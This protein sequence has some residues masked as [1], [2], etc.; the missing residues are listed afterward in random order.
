MVGYNIDATNSILLAYLKH[1][2]RVTCGITMQ[3]ECIQPSFPIHV[4]PIDLQILVYV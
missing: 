1:H 4:Y 3:W 2:F